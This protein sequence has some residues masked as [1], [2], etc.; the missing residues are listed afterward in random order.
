M[1]KDISDNIINKK[2]AI[3]YINKEIQTDFSEKKCII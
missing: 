2:K 1:S 3:K